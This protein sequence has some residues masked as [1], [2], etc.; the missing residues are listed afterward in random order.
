MKDFCCECGNT[1]ESCSCIDEDEL[2]LEP[3]FKNEIKCILVGLEEY[4][5][6]KDENKQ[7]KQENEEIIS[8]SQW[9]DLANRTTTELMQCKRYITELKEEIKQ[10]KKAFKKCSPYYC[11]YVDSDAPCVF[12]GETG[13]FEE[14]HSEDCQYVRLTKESEVPE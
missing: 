2:Y 12:C 5:K 10:L 6:L 3:K 1:I 11:D 8:E 14:A 13:Q 4:N 9:H 7:L